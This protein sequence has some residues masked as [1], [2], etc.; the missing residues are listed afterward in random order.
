MR[1]GACS[2][3]YPV[4][5]FPLS[6]PSARPAK[7]NPLLLTRRRSASTSYFF[8]SGNLSK[9]EFVVGNGMFFLERSRPIR[10][11]CIDIFGTVKLEGSYCCRSCLL[12]GKKKGETRP[13]RYTDIYKLYL[14]RR[15]E[16]EGVRLEE[17]KEE[18][19][20]KRWLLR[21]IKWCRS[22]IHRHA[23]QRC[24]CV[25]RNETGHSPCQRP[26]SL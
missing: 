26:L 4:W 12:L 10:F 5:F 8:S 22:N 25:E 1:A 15:I 17:E 21:E 16:V 6:G 9:R 20:K 7:W 23:M 13:I 18:R 14:W 2:P 3:G 24:L 19:E 11:Y